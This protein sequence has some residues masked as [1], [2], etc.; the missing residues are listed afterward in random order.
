[1]M[2]GGNIHEESS[3][4]EKNQTETDRADVRRQNHLLQLNN[5]DSETA[6]YMFIYSAVFI[7]RKMI[8]SFVIYNRSNSITRRTQG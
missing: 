1:M 8:P 6:E 5:S 3:E 7:S 2:E 4:S